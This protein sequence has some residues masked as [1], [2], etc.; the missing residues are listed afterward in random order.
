MINSAWECPRCKR[1]N[2]PF[3]PT[4]FCHKEAPFK[5][6]DFKETEKLAKNNRCSNCGGF[7][8]MWLGLPVNCVDLKKGSFKDLGND[9]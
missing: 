2:A 1:I 5:P 9:L 6:V 4:C 3:N 8:G 7:H